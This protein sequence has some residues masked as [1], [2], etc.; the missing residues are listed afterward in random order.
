MRKFILMLVLA[1][2]AG[3][4]CVNAQ[5]ATENSKVTD[6]VSLGITGGVMT[7]LDMN[8][9][10]PVNPAAGLKLTKDFSPAFGLELEGLAVLNDNHFS[11]LKTSLKA[12]NVGLAGVVNLSNALF[13]YPGK[14]RRF[15]AKLVA[16]LGWLHSWNTS[17]NFLSSKT[18]ID[19]AFNLG[20]SRAHSIVLTPGIYWNLGGIKDIQF[21]KHN[22]QFALMASYVYHFKTSNGTH[23]FKTYDIGAMTDEINELRARLDEARNRPVPAASVVVKPEKVVEKIVVRIESQWFVQFAKASSE[24]TDAAMKVLDG[25]PE[26]T[27]VNIIGTASPEGDP[28]FNFQLSRDRAETVARYLSSRSIEVCECEG[29]GVSDYSNRLAIITVAD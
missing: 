9:V 26:G 5:I 12:T 6:N 15:E 19:L 8:S 13:G 25:I 10:F 2:L 28:G 24:L 20:K 1:I 18:G 29:I 22:A 21:N 14:P 27:K 7:P 23:H 16:G 17:S 4:G 11:D 3:T